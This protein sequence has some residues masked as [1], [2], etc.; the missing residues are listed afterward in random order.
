MRICYFCGYGFDDKFEVFRS[1]FCP[2]CQKDVKVCKNCKFYSP[3]SHWDCRETIG[4]AVKE[5]DR[6]NFC[7]YFTFKEPDK[8]K[9]KE[10]KPKQED[11]KDAFDKLF[12]D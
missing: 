12:G 4:E 9:G 11:A 1:T 6:A 10:K 3:G 7:S 2:E 8:E 5:K